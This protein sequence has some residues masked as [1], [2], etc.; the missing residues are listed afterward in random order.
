MVTLTITVAT[1]LAILIPSTATPTP[2]PT[3]TLYHVTLLRLLPWLLTLF[4]A[5]AK[6]LTMAFGYTVFFADPLTHHHVSQLKVLHLLSSLF[7]AFILQE[8]TWLTSPLSLCLSSVYKRKLH[9][10]LLIKLHI[11]YSLSPYL[12]LFFIMS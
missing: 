8:F 4:R 9:Q 7:Q 6:I 3:D 10:G 2:K 5:I 12:A 11:P 1:L